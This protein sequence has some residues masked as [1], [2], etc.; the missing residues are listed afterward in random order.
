MSNSLPF[1]SERVLLLLSQG[2]P[3]IDNCLCAFHR[4][5]KMK[6]NPWPAYL[7]CAGIFPSTLPQTGSFY[8][9][10]SAA[11]RAGLLLLACLILPFS[12]LLSYC[13]MDCWLL[14][15]ILLP[16]PRIMCLFFCFSWLWNWEKKQHMSAMHVVFLSLTNCFWV[17]FFSFLLQCLQ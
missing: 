17:W 15:N 14:V 10:S 1:L 13:L 7:S 12:L 4:I 2:V 5:V 16:W 3:E 9:Q 8:R 6:I 11:R